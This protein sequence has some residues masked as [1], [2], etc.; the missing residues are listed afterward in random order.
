MYCISMWA[1]KYI[2]I[3][4]RNCSSL[5]WDLKEFVVHVCTFHQYGACTEP[6]L[7]TGG[8][9]LLWDVFFMDVPCLRI[10]VIIFC[11][12]LVSPNVSRQLLMEFCILLLWMSADSQ[13][14]GKH[15]LKFCIHKCSLIYIIILQ[16]CSTL[17]GHCGS[18]SPYMEISTLLTLTMQIL[19]KF[20]VSPVSSKNCNR[21]FRWY[22]CILRKPHIRTASDGH[23]F[24]L[25]T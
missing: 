15:S 11:E 9:Q 19:A 6:H 16:M 2:I 10:F 25:C 17:I 22:Y 13:N 23:R 1:L 18:T 20:P 5:K 4:K 21:P 3:H 24:I 14:L 12:A 7:Y 8:I